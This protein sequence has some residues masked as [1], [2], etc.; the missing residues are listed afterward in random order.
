MK[1]IYY[2]NRESYMGTK[3]FEYEADTIVE[4]DKKFI[5]KFKIV[6]IKTPWIGVTVNE[7]SL[8]KV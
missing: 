7:K 6:P 5:E 3:M 1:F 8:D 2:D 4:A